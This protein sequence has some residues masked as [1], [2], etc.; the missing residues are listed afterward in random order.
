MHE[1]EFDEIFGC[2]SSAVKA[3]IGSDEEGWLES[4]Y[5]E[6]LFVLRNLRSDNP[7]QFEDFWG[8]FRAVE[9]LEKFSFQ[10]RCR[11]IYLFLSCYVDW[12]STKLTRLRDREGNINTVYFIEKINK[13]T[14][15]I[16]FNFQNVVDQ[17]QGFDPSPEQLDEWASIFAPNTNIQQTTDEDFP[18]IV[19]GMGKKSKSGRKPKTE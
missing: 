4:D 17:F 16:R 11:V 9:G 14:P 12:G 8:R 10:E 6:A 13:K 7:E 3:A 19:R 1:P 15:R 5:Q 2:D 18:E